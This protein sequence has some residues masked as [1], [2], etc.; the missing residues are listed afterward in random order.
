[1]D[2]TLPSAMELNNP[3][4]PPLIIPG[5]SAPNIIVSITDAD[6]I[7]SVKCPTHLTSSS[8]SSP[9]T[10]P[11]PTHHYLSTLQSRTLDYVS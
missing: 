1:M 11:T 4:A 9:Y 8:S 3:P 5:S 10:P 2:N 6:L 7:R